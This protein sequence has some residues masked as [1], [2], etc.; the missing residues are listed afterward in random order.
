[1]KKIIAG[2]LVLA[3][4]TTFVNPTFAQAEGASKTL[5]VAAC[6]LLRDPIGSKK[7]T[8]LSQRIIPAKKTNYRVFTYSILD[9]GKK[10][11][12]YV[13]VDGE[14]VTALATITPSYPKVNGIQKTILN[15]KTCGQ[16]GVGVTEAPTIKTSLSNRVTVMYGAGSNRVTVKG[17]VGFSTTFGLF[18]IGDRDI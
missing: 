8:F 15:I 11:Y 4:S 9:A 17:K 18:Q 12:E 14:K 13:V 3:S 6:N 5:K 1:M 16:A 10:Y 2:L 7:Y